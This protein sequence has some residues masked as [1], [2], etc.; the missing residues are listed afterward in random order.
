MTSF[1]F[2]IEIALPFFKMS[3]HAYSNEELN[4]LKF[5]S[6]VLNEFPKAL[7][8]VFIDMWNKRIA[9][10]PGYQPWDNSTAVRNMFFI[11]EIPKT[12]IPTSSSFQDWDCTALIQATLCARTFALLD[13]MGNIKTL[14]ELYVRNRK[15]IPVPF[16]LPVVSSSGD[17][18]ETIALAIDQLRLLRNT[19]CHSSN[20][21]IT[22]VT[23]DDYVKHAKEAFT[24]VNFSTTSI[25]AIANLAESDFLTAHQVQQ[26]HEKIVRLE[27]KFEEGL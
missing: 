1:S 9:S 16:H 20:S 14:G 15:P 12:H 4:F 7:R 26:L 18:D 3:L 8:H 17:P 27:D 5:A 25:D 10:I 21:L 13:S 24:A 23:F 11:R 22:K 19:Y 6:I 2:Y